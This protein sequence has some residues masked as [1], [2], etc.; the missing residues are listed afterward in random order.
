[1]GKNKITEALNVWLPFSSSYICE[2]GFSAMVGMK[3]KFRNKLQLLNSLSLKITRTDVDVSAV[4]N[5]NRTQAHQSHTLHYEKQIEFFVKLY[6]ITNNNIYSFQNYFS[7]PVKL[8][9]SR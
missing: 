6:S 5:S 9:G 3:T 1:M 2:A 4:I 7:C 8:C